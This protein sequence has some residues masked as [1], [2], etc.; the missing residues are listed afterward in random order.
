MPQ[1]IQLP[2]S[3]SAP[4]LR[5][6]PGA[7][8]GSNGF[9]GLAVSIPLK[10]HRRRSMAC[11]PMWCKASFGLHSTTEAA[12]DLSLLSDRRHDLEAG[13]RE[14]PPQLHRRFDI[15]LRNCYGYKN[16]LGFRQIWIISERWIAQGTMEARS[17]RKSAMAGLTY[18]KRL[19]MKRSALPSIRLFESASGGASPKWPR[20]PRMRFRDMLGCRRAVERACA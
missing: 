2:R 1:S 6:K 14:D 5:D 20:W 16:C 18:G 12:G 4:S 8:C 15:E 7:S 17:F 9:D 13:R 3:R 10:I 11:L 19:I